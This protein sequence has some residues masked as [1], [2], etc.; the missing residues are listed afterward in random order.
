MNLSIQS[1]QTN[2]LLKLKNTAFTG[3]YFDAHALKQNNVSV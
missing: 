3:I 2:N 1:I